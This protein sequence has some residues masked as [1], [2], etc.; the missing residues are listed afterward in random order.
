MN[1]EASQ[2]HLRLECKLA[3]LRA[4]G[5]FSA[6][7]EESILDEMESA[8][9]RMSETERNEANIRVRAFLQ[10]QAWQMM[11]SFRR[12]ASNLIEEVNL[13]VSVTPRVLSEIPMR[14]ASSD[15]SRSNTLGDRAF[16]AYQS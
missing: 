15:F 16:H 4:L 13:S 9:Y 1:S 10:E 2:L 14:R 8:W 7:E 3:R 12:Q 5:D 6:D 11:S